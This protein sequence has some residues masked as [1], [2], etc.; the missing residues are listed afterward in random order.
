[1]VVDVF[2]DVVSVQLNTIGLKRRE[3]TVFECL[4]S[5]LRPR[6]II[7]RTPAAMARAEGFEPGAGVVRGAPLE[8]LTFV[9]RGLH[10]DLPLALGQ[11]TGFYL[12]QRP[13]RARIEQLAQGRRVL[14]AF[15]FVGTFALAAARGG[16]A[17]VVAVDESALALEVAAECARKN[18][19]SD[20]IKLVRQD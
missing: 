5:L 8:R 6:A 19:L 11:K 7:D 10:Y 12:D 20:R 1:L 9:E 15:C 14:D 2:S 18:G 4:G 16:A 13:L 3:G 17:E